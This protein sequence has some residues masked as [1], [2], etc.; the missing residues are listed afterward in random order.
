[1][2]KLRGHFLRHVAIVSALFGWAACSPSSGSTDPKLRAS[3]N[4]AAKPGSG[5]S[6]LGSGNGLG[7]A[8]GFHFGF[9]ASSGFGTGRGDGS[10][11][12]DGAC[13]SNVMEPEAI[14]VEKKR[15]ITCT[16]TAPEPLALYIM[17]DN[18]GSMDDNNKWND[19][20][21]AITAFVKSDTTAHGADWACVNEDGGVVPTPP[22]LP[23]PGTGS[24]SIAIQYF[25]PEGV[26]NP[27]E[28]NGSGHSTPAVPMGPLPDNGQAIIDS[29][30]TTGPN[31]NTP[32]TGALTGGTQYCASYQASNPG[33]RCVVVL[34]TDG[35]PNGC[36]L[37]DNCPDGGGNCVDPGSAGILTP[38]ASAAKANNGVITFTVGMQGITP[39]GFVL[40]DAIAVAGGSDCTPGTPGNEAC[41]ITTGGAQGFLDALNTIRKTVQVTGTSTQTYT[42]TETTTLA[43]QWLIPKPAPGK[44][45]DKGLVNVN[46]TLGGTTQRLGNVSGQSDCASAGEGWYYDDPNTP[47][48]IM[49][50]PDTCTKLKAATDPKVEVLVGCVTEPAIFH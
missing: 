20:V 14:K 1:M 36:G 41:N 4:N 11:T 28:C 42:A 8:G 35:Q 45:F 5:D 37:T 7:D 29:L 9:D 39:A 40:L 30:G 47:T 34:V 38:I 23:P 19:A 10:L 25:H 3:A 22:D 24:I 33:K 49:T 32:T 12:R 21:A 15:N 27:D 13:G 46:V 31:G 2:S 17:L 26:N 50:C 43:C 48:K 44:T 6:S 16:A 18:S